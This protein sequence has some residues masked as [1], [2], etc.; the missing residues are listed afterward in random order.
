VCLHAT[1]LGFL[2]PDG[3]RAVFESAAPAAFRRA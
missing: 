3:R 2:H 1:R